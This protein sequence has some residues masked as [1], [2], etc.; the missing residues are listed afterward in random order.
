MQALRPPQAVALRQSRT[1]GQPTAATL[2]GTAVCP[3]PRV[4][5]ARGVLPFQAHG[6]KTLFCGGPS[7]AR[8]VVRVAAHETDADDSELGWTAEEW[9]PDF[10]TGDGGNPT[11]HR[12]LAFLNEAGAS[13]PPTPASWRVE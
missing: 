13:S 6:A 2:V 11:E 1:R 12:G 7:H 9:E 10:E 3:V 8:H 4:R 5:L